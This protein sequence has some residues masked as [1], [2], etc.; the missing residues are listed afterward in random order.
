MQELQ[1]ITDKK[2]HEFSYS[3]FWI[4]DEILHGTYKKDN[5]IISLETAKEI[6]KKRLE[7]QQGKPYLGLVFLHDSIV[8]SAEARKYMA[9]EGYAG[10]IKAAIVISSSLK[11]I[12]ANVFIMVDRPLKPTKIF[13]SYADAI[14]WLKS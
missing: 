12:M 6:V 1:N 5:S 10:V 3:D 4:E 11:A 14:K 2:I 7:I 9:N 13:T 8:M